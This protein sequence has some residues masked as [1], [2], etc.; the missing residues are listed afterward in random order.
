MV[1]APF[2]NQHAGEVDMLCPVV[3]AACGGGSS[4]SSGSGSGGHDGGGEFSSSK[5]YICF[6]HSLLI[7]QACEHA[8][9]APV[10]LYW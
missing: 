4:G 1:E 8:G 6:Q 5:K 3:A 7:S 9:L 10:A 2:E